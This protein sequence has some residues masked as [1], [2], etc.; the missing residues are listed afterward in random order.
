[1]PSKETYPIFFKRKIMTLD[2]IKISLHAQS[3]CN[4]ANVYIYRLNGH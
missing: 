3:E 2:K 4:E 1:M